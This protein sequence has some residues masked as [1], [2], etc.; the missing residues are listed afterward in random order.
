MPARPVITLMVGLPA[1]GKTTRAKEIEAEQGALRLSADEWIIS[2]FEGANPSPGRD[3]VEGRLV[4]LG[5]RAAELGMNVV[6]DFGFWATDE[7]SALRWLA[8]LVGADSRVVYLPVEPEEQ[9]ARINGRFGVTPEQT[10]PMTDTE[11]SQWREQFQPPG[12]D[13]LADGPIPAP[14]PAYANW[15]AWAAERWP[16][17]PDLSVGRG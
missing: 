11:L 2:I 16:S 1:A 17:L 15:A 6:L 12:A 14:P 8:G 5:M 7:R 9:L 3:L 13:E 10:F 4:G